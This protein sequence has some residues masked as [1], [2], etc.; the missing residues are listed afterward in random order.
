MIKKGESLRMKH[1][2][3]KISTSA[4]VTAEMVEEFIHPDKRECALSLFR[5]NGIAKIYLDCWRG[6]HIPTAETLTLVRDFFR[7]RDFEVAAGLTPTRGGFGKAS[8]DGRWWLCYTNPETQKGIEQV[9]RCVAQIFDT[10]IVDDFLCTMCFCEE[11]TQAKRERTWDAYY[12]DLLVQVTRDRI[13]APAQSENRDVHLIIK[14]P[15]WYDRF[16]VFGYDVLTHPQQFDEVWVGTE[17]RDL[18]VEY[19]HPYQAFVNYRWLASLSGNKIGG[20]WFDFINVYPEIYLEQAFQSVLAGARELI[21]FSYQ[22]A[23]YSPQNENTAALLE[24]M[25]DL[26]KLVDFIGDRPLRGIM[27]YKPPDSDGKDEAYLFDYLG[28]LGFPLL[29]CCQFPDKASAIY[30]PVH[31]ARDDAIVE[32]ATAYL[33]GGGTVL[34]S[35][36]FLDA[37][38]RPG[39]LEAKN[40]LERAG[41]NSTRATTPTDVWTYQFKVGEELVSTEAHIRFLSRLLPQEAEVLATAITSLDDIPI[42]TH[43]TG[44]T[45]DIFVFNAQ[46]FHYPPKS[47]RVTV[48]QPV[49]LP[50]LP[51]AI[52]GLLRNKLLQAFGLQIRCRSRVGVYLYGEDRLALSNFNDQAVNVEIDVL[53]ER[54]GDIEDAITGRQLGSWEGK[55]LRFT[56]PGRDRIGIVY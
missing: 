37:L 6:S 20:A 52:V 28:M 11:C 21:R 54:S 46:T 55:T 27:G 47:T 15:Q 14:Y 26:V 51:Q 44:E 13:I 1:Q 41:Y 48:A 49:P 25:P 3:R 24:K 34:M 32:K 29:P 8:T 45:G 53:T 56:I 43:C 12:V 5:V 17:I 22:P 23:L 9:V 2:K 19:V 4:F 42:L 7:E 18:R 10:I 36:G 30:L 31:A 50:H 39:T 33:E 16:H 35:P 38:Q 40:L